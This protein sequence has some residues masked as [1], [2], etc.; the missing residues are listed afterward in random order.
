MA[1]PRAEDVAAAVSRTVR[2]LRQQQQ[3]SLSTL[4]ERAEVSRSMVI[5]IEQGRT[6]P[7]LGVL[8]RLANALGVSL[9][10]LVAFEQPVPVR[11]LA[12]GSGAVMWTGENGGQGRMLA[13]SHGPIQ[14]QVWDW[15]MKSGERFTARP[16]PTGTVEIVHVL[17][18][19]LELRVGDE[20]YDV[21]A[22]S[23]AMFL[24]DRTHGY[25]NP[26]SKPLRMIISNSEPPS[27][28][29]LNKEILDA[30][31]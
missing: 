15:R 31:P 13:G 11:I 26:S 30:A 29:G 16:Q 5:Q 2:V 21:P 4:A 6:N 3:L 24:P 23:T 28:L 25:A 22:G 17:S 20:R 12:P 9:P 7:S 18:G 10:E 19:R 8:V 1:E 27:E 14:L